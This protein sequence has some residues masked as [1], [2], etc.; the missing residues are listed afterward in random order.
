MKASGH[1]TMNVFK[2]YNTVDEEELKSLA[3]E[4][5]SIDH[6]FKEESAEK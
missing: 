2:R 3:V 6:D 5:G 1:R 4:S